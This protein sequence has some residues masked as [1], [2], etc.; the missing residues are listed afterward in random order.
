MNGFPNG[1][2]GSPQAPPPPR[3]LTFPSNPIAPNHWRQSLLPC[4]SSDL[5]RMGWLLAAPAAGAADRFA[6][7]PTSWKQLQLIG[8]PETQPK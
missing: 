7:A 6:R 3:L 4:V 1:S 8:S 5:T 2:I